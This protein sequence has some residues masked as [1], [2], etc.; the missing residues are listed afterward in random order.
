MAYPG[1]NFV[2]IVPPLRPH[3]E[4]EVGHVNVRRWRL[5]IEHTITRRD[6]DLDSEVLAPARRRQHCETPEKEG[7]GRCAPHEEMFLL[8]KSEKINRNKNEQ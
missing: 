2:R 6:V 8:R 1:Q 4:D 5:D 7:D 3:L